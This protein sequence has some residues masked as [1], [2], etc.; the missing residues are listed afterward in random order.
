MSTPARYNRT[1]WVG[2]HNPW[3]FAF[4]SNGT[5]TTTQYPLAGVRVNVTVF[6]GDEKLVEKSTAATPSPTVTVTGER[7]DTIWTPDDTR[8]IAGA[9]YE[10]GVKP[11]YEVEFWNGGT[12]TT[13]VW[14]TITL[15]GGANIDE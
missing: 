15:Q 6:N 10:D 2:N 13:W 12:E 5:S 3:A 4:Y 9:T 8:V 14:G 7:I 11:R 1:L